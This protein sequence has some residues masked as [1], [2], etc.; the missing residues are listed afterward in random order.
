MKARV[1]VVMGGLLSIG[2]LSLGCSGGGASTRGGGGEK[3]KGDRTRV[4]HSEGVEPM[5]IQECPV[6]TDQVLPFCGRSSRKA[7][8]KMAYTEAYAD[9]LGQLTRFVGQKVEARIEPDGRGGYSFQ[10]SSVGDEKVS[11]TGV[12]EGERWCE[13]YDG[14]E[15][16]THDCFVMLTYPKLEYDKLLHQ[17][18]Q[19]AAQRMQKAVELHRQGKQMASQGRH[20]EAAMLLERAK[21]LLTQLK[22]PRVV[23][24]LSSE[25]LA[26]QIAADLRASAQA[27]AEAGKTALVVMGLTLE[28]KLTTR[29]GLVTTMQNMIQKWVVNQGLKIRPG[30][31][32]SDQVQAILSGDK[33]AAQQA[34]ASKGAGM[35]LVVDLKCDFG[36]ELH[37]QFFSYAEGGLRLIRTADGRELYTTELE[38]TKAGHVTRKN[39]NKKALMSVLNKFVQPAVQAAVA[40]TR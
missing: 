26:E 24:G 29:G 25:V 6:H 8:E 27:A 3:V 32:D 1:A 22:E 33:E 11:L 23:E 18:H 7:S 20:P 36:S 31:L 13:E 40:K 14:S 4:S 16:R 12:W 17:A 39:A 35:L 5:W 21:K 15:G 19:I 37:G 38:R 28:G 34:A 10:M 30:G 9:A 2:L